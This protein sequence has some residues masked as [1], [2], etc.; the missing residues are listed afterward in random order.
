MK[1]LFWNIRG[2]GRPDRRRQI[3][4]YIKEEWL[5]G[6]GLQESMKE[7]FTQTEFEAIS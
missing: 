1:F 5:D 6:V 7:N 3:R 2:F 4:E